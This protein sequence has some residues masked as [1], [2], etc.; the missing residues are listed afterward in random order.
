MR[1]NSL[2]PYT[3]KEL[4]CSRQANNL[5]GH[6]GPSFKA[7]RWFGERTPLHGHFFDHGAA[8]QKR[9]KLFQQRITRVKHAHAVGAAH[10]VPGKRSKIY[11]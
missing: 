4:G 10:L 7:L 11:T 6:L 1:C 9:R 3:I 5:A 8:C 2:H